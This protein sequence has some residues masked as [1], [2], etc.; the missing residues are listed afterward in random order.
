MAALV[1]S[2][3]DATDSRSGGCITKPSSDELNEEEYDLE[4]PNTAS[5]TVAEKRKTQQTR[6]GQ[7]LVRIAVGPVGR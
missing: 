5:Q 1:K 2:I 3:G 4:N 6:L 7:L